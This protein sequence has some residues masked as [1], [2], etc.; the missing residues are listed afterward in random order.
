L[1]QSCFVLP[2][3]RTASEPNNDS[4]DIFSADNR[5]TFSEEHSNRR[6]L[7]KRPC[8]R[9]RDWKKSW[10]DFFESVKNLN[11]GNTFYLNSYQVL[12]C[13]IF[14]VTI[15]QLS[16]K[17]YVFIF[18]IKFVNYLILAFFAIKW[19]KVIHIVI[20]GGL[21]NVTWRFSLCYAIKCSSVDDFIF[22]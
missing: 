21:C 6:H 15:W 3:S 14:K 16:A 22:K 2:S 11:F 19:K 5:G 4:S 17:S 12:N 9:R 1:W 8:D 7:V 10:F 18:I 13:S 20:L